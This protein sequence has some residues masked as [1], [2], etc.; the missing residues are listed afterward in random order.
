MVKR[1]RGRHDYMLWK[2]QK[3]EG[4]II[5]GYRPITNPAQKIYYRI[6]VIIHI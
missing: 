6:D 4:S 1:S 3:T 2:A 5:M